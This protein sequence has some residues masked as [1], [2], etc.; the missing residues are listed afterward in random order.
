MFRQFTDQLLPCR[1]YI[2]EPHLPLAASRYDDSSVMG[3]R[4]CGNSLIMSV[5]NR[6]YQP[7]GERREGPDYTIVPAREDRRS[8]VGKRKA[9]TAEVLHA[10]SQ[11]LFHG[12]HAPYAHRVFTGGGQNVA[13]FARIW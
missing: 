11:E 2:P 12:A 6:V 8:V 13:E 7:A 4:K 10:D 3:D 5:Q 1:S 9:G